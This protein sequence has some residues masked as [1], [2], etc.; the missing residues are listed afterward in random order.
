MQQRSAPPPNAQG[1]QVSMPQKKA[2]RPQMVGRRRDAHKPV[3]RKPAHTED[4]TSAKDC[5][6]VAAFVLACFAV[7]YAFIFAYGCFRWGWAL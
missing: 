7:M 5:L 6:K 2:T 3:R 1:R 4:Y